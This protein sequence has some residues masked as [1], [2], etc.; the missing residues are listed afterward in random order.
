MEARSKLLPNRNQRLK[1]KYGFHNHSYRR[2]V[3][4]LHWR[5]S[6]H[7]KLNPPPA[8]IGFGLLAGVAMLVYAK[9]LDA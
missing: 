4:G 1:S 9:Q 2:R 3:Q 5:S 6:Q 8:Q 7:H